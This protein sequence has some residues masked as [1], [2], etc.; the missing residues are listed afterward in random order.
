MLSHCLL[1]REK[2]KL[3]TTMGI[4]YP[5]TFQHVLTSSTDCCLLIRMVFSLFTL[6]FQLPQHPPTSMFVVVSGLTGLKCN[7]SAKQMLTQEWNIG[8][9]IP[10]PFSSFYS[11]NYPEVVQLQDFRIFF[12]IGKINEFFVVVLLPY[13]YST[14]WIFP[15]VY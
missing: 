12:I 5:P 3:L 7:N 15:P 14:S 8:N 9:H 1:W 11:S 13:L 2:Y 10:N 4:K 6:Q